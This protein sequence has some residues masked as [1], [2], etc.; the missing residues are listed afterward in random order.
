MLA[1]YKGKVAALVLV[2]SAVFLVAGTLANQA[3]STGASP[4]FAVGM[5]GGV[6]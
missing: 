6:I 4:R 1:N 5:L 3:T 2:G